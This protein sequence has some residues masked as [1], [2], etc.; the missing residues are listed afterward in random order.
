V[1]TVIAVP[2]SG[3]AGNY[4]S[5]DT[6]AKCL[7]GHCDSVPTTRL[8]VNFHLVTYRMIRI[9]STKVT[10]LFDKYTGVMGTQKHGWTRRVKKEL[11]FF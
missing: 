11:R 1:N 2:N 5:L 9:V 8:L 10:C 3:L 4:T 7:P 6:H